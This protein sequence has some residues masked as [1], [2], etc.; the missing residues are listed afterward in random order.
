MAGPAA[1]GAIIALTNS[2]VPV[3][4]TNAVAVFVCLGLVLMVRIKQQLAPKQEFSLAKYSLAD[5]IL[6][7][8]TASFPGAITL[9]LF[10]VFFGGATALLPQYAKEILHVGPQGLGLLQAALPIGSLVCALYMAHRP[11]M[12]KA[13]RSL[14]LRSRIW[15]GDDCVWHFAL[16]LVFDGRR[17]LSAGSR[18]TSA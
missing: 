11:P 13:G 1:G 5:F 16:V 4:V 15:C 12:Q 14:I 9:D 17:C 3:Y 7:F 18:I 8:A 6:Y 10:A 2:A